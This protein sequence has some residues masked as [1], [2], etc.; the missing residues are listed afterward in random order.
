ML[1]LRKADHAEAAWTGLAK[2]PAQ[3]PQKSVLS[4]VGQGEAYSH[5]QRH[6]RCSQALLEG[7]LGQGNGLFFR[8]W[9]P[10]D[11]ERITYFSRS[12]LISSHTVFAVFIAV[13]RASLARIISP[14]FQLGLA[15]ASSIAKRVISSSIWSSML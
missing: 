8:L 7:S 15:R 14:P 5:A 2:D 10:L 4:P 13:P 1:E 3:A 6:G 11:T 12:R 9:M